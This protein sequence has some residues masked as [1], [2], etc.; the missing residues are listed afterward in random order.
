ML[1]RRFR[2]SSWSIPT[3]SLLCLRAHQTRFT[4]QGERFVFGCVSCR[5]FILVAIGLSTCIFFFFSRKCRQSVT[6]PPANQ[7]IRVTSRLASTEKFGFKRTLSV[8]IHLTA[9]LLIMNGPDYGVFLGSPQQVPLGIFRLMLSRKLGTTHTP[10]PKILLEFPSRV[11]IGLVYSLICRHSCPR[12]TT[13][14]RA[15]RTCYI[16]F[17]PP[18][19]PTNPP[20]SP[21]R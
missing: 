6:P 19:S 13:P 11:Q 20:N 17:P 7:V 21:T 18:W 15:H 3:P 4:V 14:A 1:T 9:F 5:L 10:T 2:H 16:T 12:R 8:G